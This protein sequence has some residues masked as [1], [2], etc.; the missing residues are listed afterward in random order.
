MDPAVLVEPHRMGSCVG[1]VG[2]R[3]GLTGIH[4]KGMGAIA[5]SNGS[6]RLSKKSWDRLRKDHQIVG[7]LQGG[8]S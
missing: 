5:F 1:P 2:V 4:M 3:K 8:T 7:A 6:G